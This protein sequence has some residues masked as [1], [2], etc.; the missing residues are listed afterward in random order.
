MFKQLIYSA[1][2]LA[3]IA[4]WPLVTHAQTHQTQPYNEHVDFRPPLD[5]NGYDAAWYKFP[6][7]TNSNTHFGF[8]LKGYVFGIPVINGKYEG[9][10][11]NGK[12]AVRSFLKTAGIG[13][14]L[15]KLKIWA[16]TDGTYDRSGLYPLAHT[17]QNLDKKSR[18]V[19]MAY[20]YG[21]RSIDVRIYPRIG[22]QG[23]PPATPKER[24]EADDTLSAVLNLMMRQSAH[25]KGHVD[26]PLCAGDVKV[27]DSKQHYALRMVQGKPDRK[28][29]L[30][31]K[32]DIITCKIYYIPISGF[33]PE[34]LPS[35]KEAGTPIDAQ[36]VK[37]DELD[38]YIPMRLSYK[39]S[40]FKAVIKITDMN[41]NGR[42]LKE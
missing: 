38:M 8:D 41:V 19:K 1:A 22:S 4:A 16:I 6:A 15:K 21:P 18:R 20:D 7:N 11:E 40:G 13:A 27:F 25:H 39:I 23:I 32:T 5:A 26:A 31:K 10:M 37:N 14:L 2:I 9:A 33:D 17:Q 42:S 28:K 30:G 3:S 36:L 29:F 24:F 35:K 12:Y 34:D